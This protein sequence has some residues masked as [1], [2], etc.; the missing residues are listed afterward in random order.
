MWIS[1]R[2]F[3]RIFTCKIWLRYSRE[4]ALL[5]FRNSRTAAHAQADRGAAE[6]PA[7][8]TQRP[9]RRK[10][11]KQRRPTVG[12]LVWVEDRYGRRKKYRFTG[13]PLRRRPEVVNGTTAD[14]QNVARFRLY[15]HRFLQV[16][17]RFSEFFKI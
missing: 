1:A 9:D 8:Q 14:R 15:R 3:K 2:A 4:R 10:P 17:T 11:R 7:A 5:S 6:Q 12:S 13:I 16:N